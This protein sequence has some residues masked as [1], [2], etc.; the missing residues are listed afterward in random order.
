[1]NTLLNICHTIVFVFLL[2][3]IIDMSS[4]TIAY[5]FKKASISGIK[6]LEKTA[7]FGIIMY[8]LFN[9]GYYF[10]GIILVSK[11]ELIMKSSDLIM[12]IAQ[13]MHWASIAFVVAALIVTAVTIFAALAD[14][15]NISELKKLLGNCIVI[16]IIF[17]ILAWLII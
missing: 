1:M 13:K 15:G 8:L 10:L 3:S 11:G 6:N 12:S 14:D 7:L 9:I 5:A 16:A 17:W 4:C 2:A